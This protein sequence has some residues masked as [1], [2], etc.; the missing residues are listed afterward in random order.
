MIIDHSTYQ[1]RHEELRSPEMTEFMKA[2]GFR[3]VLPD[4]AIEGKGWDVRWWSP[5]DP[6]WD[7]LCTIVH[8]VGSKER[9]PLG[10]AHFCVS[11]VGLQRYDRLATSEWCER[12][13]GSGRIWLA[14][15]GGLR[16]EVRP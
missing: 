1:V 7:K 5:V 12:D 13:S 14:G 10:L 3:E 2:L 6:T 9:H 15:P 4:E 8:L 16:V 11:G